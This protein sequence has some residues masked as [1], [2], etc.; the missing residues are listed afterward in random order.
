MKSTAIPLSVIMLRI[1][2]IRV[3]AP[4]GQFS[5]NCNSSGDAIPMALTSKQEKMLTLS[6]AQ[7]VKLNRKD[8][9]RCNVWQIVSRRIEDLL[10]GNA[11]D[12]DVRK[13]GYFHD[14]FDLDLKLLCMVGIYDFE[15]S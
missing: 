13:C 8:R 9:S 15:N 4:V 7:S 12:N 1:L 14:L 10:V 11:I 2:A 6:T 3:S 5:T